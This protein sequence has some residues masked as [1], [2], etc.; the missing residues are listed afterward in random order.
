[1]VAVRLQLVVEGGHALG[2]EAVDGFFFLDGLAGLIVEEGEVADVARQI[3]QREGN[4]A[5]REQV[6]KL[7]GGEVGDDDGLGQVV[8]R[9]GGKVVEGL[10]LRPGKVASGRFLLSEELARPEE[11]D[12]A[13]PSPSFL[14]GVFEE[15]TVAT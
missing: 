13:L 14:D 3:L 6:A 2:G 8:V 5:I 11:V 10:D 9:H 1:D 15:G 12:E 7:E 4:D